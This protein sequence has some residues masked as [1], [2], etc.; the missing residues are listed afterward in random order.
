METLTIDANN[1][2]LGASL[3]KWTGNAGYSPQTKG[4][5]P[6]RE[7]GVLYAQAP[8]TD[9]S[10][11]E[12]NVVASIADPNFAGNDA[13]ILD[14]E[15]KFYTLNAGALTKRQTD[16]TRSFVAGTSDMIFFD[17]RVFATSTTNIAM[18]TGADLGTIDQTWWTVTR[19]HGSLNGNF[20][21]PL[22]V[23]EDTMYIADA[24]LIH[25][26][27]G[28]TSVP[29]ALI[30]P[31]IWNITCLKKHPNGRDLIAFCAETANYSH[32]RGSRAVAFIINT[33]TLEFTQEIS[34]GQ[35]VEG[36]RVVGGIVY[37]TYGQNLGYFTDSG[38]EFLRKLEISLVGGQLAY[39]HHLGDMDGHLL[40]VEGK[41]I[42]AFGDL[43]GGKVFWYPIA[44]T[45]DYGTNQNLDSILF[46]GAGKLVFGSQTSGGTEK[47][48]QCD[49][50]A[51]ANDAVGKN[52]SKF[53][54]NPITF[55][56]KVWIRRIEIQHTALASTHEQYL[57]LEDVAENQTLVKVTTFAAA[58]AQVTTRADCN[59]YGDFI[60][61]NMSYVLGNLATLPG[62]KKAIIYYEP[63]E[64]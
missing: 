29:S 5:N 26:W 25:T 59:F 2:I 53:Y 37:V 60:R 50:T 52:L 35:Q 56:S 58:G 36:A 11:L 44:N 7:P 20:R 45:T 30:L 63:A 3:N 21:H 47:L 62:F 18:A 27:D 57:Y 42:L 10:N 9:I 23:V 41:N 8:F 43:G 14:D 12:G 19:G 17:T 54:S 49:L 51:T 48:Y 16:S 1:F 32:T 13:Y 34:I 22:E 6:L 24:N 40:V 55:P 64:T 39:K 38:I 4:I 33:V 61:F 31:N 15:G 46:I 28:T